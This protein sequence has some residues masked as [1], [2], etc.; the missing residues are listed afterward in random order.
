MFNPSFILSMINNEHCPVMLISLGILVLKII[1]VQDVCNHLWASDIL[2]FDS[3]LA[4]RRPRNSGVYI[5]NF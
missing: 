2:F 3:N 1:Q 5:F 4:M